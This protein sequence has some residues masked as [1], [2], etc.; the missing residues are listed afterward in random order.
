MEGVVFTVKKKKGTEGRDGRENL[1]KRKVRHSV[2][3]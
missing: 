1:V 2:N 3:I